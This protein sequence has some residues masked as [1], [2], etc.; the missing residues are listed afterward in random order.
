MKDNSEH[1][2]RVSQSDLV[3]NSDEKLLEF[4]QELSKNQLEVHKRL[5][6]LEETNELLLG[7]LV[8][9]STKVF[10]QKE[11]M[12]QIEQRMLKEFERFQTGGPQR[13]MS[14]IFHKLF[15]EL[16]EPVNELDLLL[17]PDTFNNRS[18][19]ELAWL[20]ALEIIRGKLEQ[21]LGR[22]GCLPIPVLEGEA[23]FNPELH[24][25]VEADFLSDEDVAIASGKI[26]EVKQ[27]GWAL[28]GNI[29]QLPKVI[30]K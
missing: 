17:T 16:L 13:A 1:N 27:R 12:S 4:L 24:E 2:Q 9:L 29:I 10:S 19:G 14:A 26:I 23:D 11:Q 21:L 3:P 7:Q 30:V 6:K 5:N 15:R 22:W 20:Q 8:E 28:N 18:E 25:A